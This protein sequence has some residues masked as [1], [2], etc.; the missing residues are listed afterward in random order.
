MGKTKILFL[1][2]DPSDCVRLR[3]GQELRDIREKLQL[4]KQWE[5]FSLESRESV[6]PGDITQAIF[7][8]EPQIIH[9]S[10][11]GN[12]A[13]GLCF[14]NGS[15]KSQI[16]EAGVLASLFELVAKQIN[17]VVLNACYSEIQAKAIAQ[18]IPFVVGMGQAIGDKAAIIFATG[19]YKAL[20]AGRSFEDAYKFARV[21]ILLE[22]IPESLTPILYC[23]GQKFVGDEAVKST[24]Y[25]VVLS[26]TIDAVDKPLLETIVS[27]LHQISGDAS[28]TVQ[29]VEPGSIRLYLEG[30]EDGF[31]ELDSLFTSGKLSKIL[32]FEIQEIDKESKQVKDIC[33]HISEMIC[34]KRDSL[35]SEL[36]YK[37]TTL[38]LDYCPVID[39]QTERCTGI[40]TTR[41]IV[42]RLPPKATTLPLE[43]QE[44][45][46][47]VTDSLNSASLRDELK[48]LASQKIEELFPE[49]NLSNLVTIQSTASVIEAIEVFS[50]RH[51][52]GRRLGYVKCIPVLDG[53]GLFGFISYIDVL[54]K[55]IRKQESYLQI[56]IEML[57]RLSSSTEFP[58]LQESD[59]VSHA[60]FLM[61]STGINCIPVIENS[62]D[63]KLIGLVEDI[64][65]LTFKHPSFFALLDTLS[66]RHI[67]TRRERLCTI[68][69][70]QILKDCIESFTDRSYGKP[71]SVLA[72]CD[73]DM[74][75]LGFLSY[76]DILRGW[77]RIRGTESAGK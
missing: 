54:R 32:G 59:P 69:P 67:M 15:G 46:N 68:T 65:I 66:I 27:H 17:C 33:T 24:K 51:D 6:R 58:S 14:E 21:E 62:E 23:M 41:D 18:H 50:K 55:I 63:A 28:L 35:F 77:Q 72:V 45:I 70:G 29:K 47:I 7:D 73:T 76:L 38:G 39:P 48:R 8:V 2:S 11:H 49:C 22:G 19:F 64:Q 13:G 26:A 5:D 31:K 4:S 12:S 52:L 9:F 61:N 25:V 42:K 20:G 60:Y 57:A 16:V 37:M 10:G 40:I 30:S 56:P 1:A 71:P 44:K 36:Y 74:H 53:E 34:V 43:L 3:L 75:L